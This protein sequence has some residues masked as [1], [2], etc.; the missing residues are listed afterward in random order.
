MSFEKIPAKDTRWHLWAMRLLVRDVWVLARAVIC[1]AAIHRN[2]F[3]LVNNSYEIA[4]HSNMR[5]AIIPALIKRP[6]VTVRRNDSL[7]FFF[8]FN[9]SL[10]NSYRRCDGKFIFNAKLWRI[11]VLSLYTRGLTPTI[12]LKIHCRE[13]FAFWSTF[14]PFPR[15]IPLRST[16]N[17][18][19]ILSVWNLL[20]LSTR[21]KKI[22]S[23]P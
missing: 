8:F 22:Q 19:L 13:F 3:E 2:C 9:F 7:P 5:D 14:L 10:R 12:T 15:K 6:S 17:S 18:L 23:Y 16:V 1:S 11:I 21:K 4:P 20:S